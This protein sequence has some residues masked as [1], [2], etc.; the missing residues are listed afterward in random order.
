MTEE[1]LMK[2]AQKP[3]IFLENAICLLALMKLIMGFA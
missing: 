1:A 2:E 3:C